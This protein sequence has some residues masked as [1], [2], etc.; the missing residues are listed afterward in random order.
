M[1]CYNFEKNKILP[2]GLSVF[3]FAATQGIAFDAVKLLRACNDPGNG[4]AAGLEK[5][6]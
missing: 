3:Y 2:P 4:I 6:L 1:T 5:P